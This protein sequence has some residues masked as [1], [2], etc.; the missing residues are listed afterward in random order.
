MRFRKLRIAW[1][2]VWGVIAV[3]LCMLWVRSYQVADVVQFD[4]GHG[5][6]LVVNCYRGE[7]EFATADIPSPT[8]QHFYYQIVRSSKVKWPGWPT[9]K[10]GFGFLNAN[11][12]ELDFLFPHWF[13][14]TL[15]IAA[16]VL[17]W[18][19]FRRFSLRTL[20]ITMTLVAVVLGLIVWLG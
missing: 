13:L 11:R 3:L 18:V 17:P 10:F 2:V 19:L 8:G 15:A 6:G 4:S 12:G 5:W 20:L 16:G 14:I 7:V 1:S 9:V